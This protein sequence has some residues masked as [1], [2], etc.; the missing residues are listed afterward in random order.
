VTLAA[1]TLAVTVG[2]LV[3]V[4]HTAEIIAFDHW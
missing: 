1:A 2:M 4:P 3:V